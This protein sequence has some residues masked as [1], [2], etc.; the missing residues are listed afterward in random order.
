MPPISSK[1]RHLYKVIAW[2]ITSTICAGLISWA[3]LGE[4]TTA[5]TLTLMLAVVMT[6]VHYIFEMAWEEYIDNGL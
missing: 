1:R 5:T 3:Y 2:R 4:F 6:F